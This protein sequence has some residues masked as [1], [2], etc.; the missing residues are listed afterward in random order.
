MRGVEEGKEE[1]PEGSEGGGEREEGKERGGRGEIQV[2]PRQHELEDGV[3]EVEGGG[4]GERDVRLKDREDGKH[5]VL[6]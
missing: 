5:A 2:D 3:D 4:G 6:H 1:E